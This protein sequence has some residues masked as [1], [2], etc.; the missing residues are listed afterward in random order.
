LPTQG[1]GV[2]I[3]GGGVAVGAIASALERLVGVLTMIARR[4]YRRSPQPRDIRDGVGDG[5]AV[6]DACDTS[7]DTTAAGQIGQRG[8]V[9]MRTYTDV[10]WRVTA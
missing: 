1:S 3:G 10:Q 2:V 4:N 5:V 7:R 8:N 9:T 6:F